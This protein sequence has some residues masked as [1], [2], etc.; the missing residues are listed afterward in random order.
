ML[1]DPTSCRRY[2][3]YCQIHAALRL[4]LRAN[5]ATQKV[6]QQINIE[7]VVPT[8][9]EFA[10]VKIAAPD[11]PAPTFP[12]SLFP[13]TLGYSSAWTISYLSATVITGLLILGFWLMPA[14]RP[15]QVARSAVPS[16]P[17]VEPKAYVGRIT[18]V[19]DCKIGDSRVSLGQKLDLASGLMEITYDTGAKVILQGPVTYSVEA[20]GGYLAVGKLTGKLEKKAEV[21]RLASRPF[22]IRTPIATVTDL[23]TE[24]AVEVAKGGVSEVHVLQGR[25]KVQH[26]G[27]SDTA[28][29]EVTLSQGQ[30]V[31]VSQT[32]PGY[33][34]IPIT[35]SKFKNM[36]IGKVHTPPLRWPLLDKT[37][38]AWVSLANL[39]QRGVGVFSIDDMSKYDGIVFG[40]L[41]P[42]KWTAGS[43]DGTRYYRGQSACRAETARPGELVQIAIVY[44]WTSI[45]I[46]RN[47]ERYA[48]Y[49]VEHR[50]AFP[51]DS[52]L[53]IGRRGLGYNLGTTPMLSGTIKEARLYNVALSPKI[54]AS[55]KPN[56][57]SPIGPVG[58]WT[59]EHGTARDSTGHFPMGQLQGNA[60]ITGGKLVLD[61]QNSYLVIPAVGGIKQPARVASSDFERDV[62]PW[63][64]RKQSDDGTALLPAPE[65]ISRVTGDTPDGSEGALPREHR[66]ARP[67]V[68]RTFLRCGLSVAGKRTGGHNSPHQLLRQE[69]QRRDMAQRESA[70]RRSRSGA[71]AHRSEVAAL[72]GRYAVGLDCTRDKLSGV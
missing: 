11:S 25:V 10:A 35:P 1:A 61:G 62:T 21:L 41:E 29:E 53:V 8:P 32:Q 64:G 30:A 71:S 3:D 6:H 52:P 60:R 33:A 47:G 23:G 31:R 9:S 55:L 17:I 20:N 49:D 27:Q 58:L 14:S 36:P 66:A 13:S 4:Q 57:P 2:L 50:Q 54:I 24:F 69:H 5:R 44:D 63:F 42:K 59:F 37:L 45:T 22:T 70:G 67:Q 72:S 16:V 15:E 34:F 48:Q 40:E 46:Y 38:V 39:D 51:K 65:M 28:H 19:V 68:L 7:S 26:A 43:Y 12:T 18:G 56:E